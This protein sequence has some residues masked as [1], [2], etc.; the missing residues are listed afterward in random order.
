MMAA[1]LIIEARFSVDSVHT[2]VKLSY[3]VAQ[4]TLIKV[5][6]AEFILRQI[7]QT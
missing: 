6:A 1:R 5:S 3:Q 2:A 4:A 7:E